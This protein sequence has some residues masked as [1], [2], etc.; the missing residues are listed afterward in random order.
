MP[1]YKQFPNAEYPPLSREEIRSLIKGEGALRPAVIIHGHWIHVDELSEYKHKP[2][3]DLHERMPCDAAPFYMK[4]PAIFGKKGEFCY[5]DVEGADPSLKRKPGE[6]VAVDEENALDWDVIE[7]ISENCPDAEHPD[8]F[9][10]APQEDGRYRLMSITPFFMWYQVKFRG[11]QN[12]LL[13]MYLEPERVHKLNQ[14]RLKYI[15][16][17]MERGVQEANIDGITVLDDIGMQT[18]PFMSKELFDEFYLPYYKKVCERAH[19]L[20]IDVWFHSCGDIR[21]LLPS[22]VEAGI[23]VL[24]PVQ[25]YCMDEKEI[26]ETYGDDLA[27]WC[28][29]DLQRLFPFGNVEDIRAETRFLADT[30]WQPHKGKMI[31]TISNRIGNNVPL[32]NYLAF[33]E[34]AYRYGSQIEQKGNGQHASPAYADK[35]KWYGIEATTTS[36]E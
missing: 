4:K 26:V 28:G 10:T 2:I 14:K 12:T 5:C 17:T 15:L 20:G 30:F 19:E 6:S 1:L 33:V 29:F 25:K 27:F 7:Q 32:E 31:Y 24:H 16:R 3:N 13:D 18:G 9:E 8:L 23:D 11:L 21:E 34:E 22:L 36:D 35:E